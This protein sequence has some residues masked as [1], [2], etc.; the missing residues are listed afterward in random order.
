MD[1][2][3][4]LTIVPTADERPTEHSQ[5]GPMDKIVRSRSA[6]TLAV[7]AAY[8]LVIGSLFDL[9][10]YVLLGEFTFLIKAHEWFTFLGF[11]AAFLAVAV[12]SWD[13]YLVKTNGVVEGWVATLATLFIAFGG[14]VGVVGSGAASDRFQAVGIGI[15]GLLALTQAARHPLAE[16]KLGTRDRSRALWLGAGI[17]LVLL[18]LSSGQNSGYRVSIVPE[19]IGAVGAA[20]LAT[21]IGVG[22]RDGQLAA[23]PTRLVLVGLA[24]AAVA[25]V[26]QAVVAAVV[27]GSSSFRFGEAIFY[28]LQVIAFVFL[29]RA[30]AS[31]TRELAAAGLP[32]WSTPSQRSSNWSATTGLERAPTTASEAGPIRSTGVA[33]VTL[34]PLTVL[35][36]AGWAP[37][38]GNRAFLNVYSDQIELG[39][40]DAMSAIPLGS[41]QDLQIEGASVTKG[42]G[43]IGGGFGAKAAAEGMLI[44]TVLNSLTTKKTK[45]VT[46]RIVAEGGWVDLRLDNYDVL[47]VRNTLRIL[48]DSVMANRS[49]QRTPSEPERTAAPGLDLVPSLDRLIEYRN[50]GILSEEE[51]QAAKGQLLNR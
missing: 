41:L 2:G 15:W 7:A 6:M 1:F 4:R 31:R 3:I 17:G 12:V 43:F 30:A 21:A 13:R 23:H 11:S 48:A 9:L 10:A 32:Y 34:G 50:S 42:G 18:A 22:R 36:G 14:L 33:S 28:G 49:S 44:S 40:G 25:F 39:P 46:I 38:I 19:I 8:L 29:G 37:Q 20:V 26:V 16:Q 35:D 47:P 27:L 51:F 45:W 5:G 24:A